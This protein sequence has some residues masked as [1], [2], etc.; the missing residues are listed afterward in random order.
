ME[1]KLEQ[2][3]RNIQQVKKIN[4]KMDNMIEFHKILTELESEGK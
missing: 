4:Q 2:V 3:D 1:E